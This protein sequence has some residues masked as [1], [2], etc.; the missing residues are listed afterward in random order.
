M[1]TDTSSISEVIECDRRERLRKLAFRRMRI[2]V[3]DGRVV[4]GRFQCF[5]KHKNVVLSE[6]EEFR[7]R[8]FKNGN[9][10]REDVR[11]IGLILIPG[12]HMVR[13]E[14]EEPDPLSVL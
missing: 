12:D 5:D 3:D 11:R 9:A 14:V 6:A 4:V 7:V 8:Y 10:S 2:T 1:T 13:C